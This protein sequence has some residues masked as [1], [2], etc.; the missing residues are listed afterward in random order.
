MSALSTA[1]SGLNAASARLGNAAN[2]IANADTPGYRARRVDLAPG[3]EGVRILG[4]SPRYAD[5]YTSTAGSTDTPPDAT[6]DSDERSAPSDVDLATEAVDVIR[7]KSLYGANAAVVRVAD[8]LIG[9]LL[10]V[11]ATD[12]PTLSRPRR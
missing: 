6:P 1:L 8:S 9:T 2:N 11:V 4:T 12:G 10:D 7:T 3:P 5:T